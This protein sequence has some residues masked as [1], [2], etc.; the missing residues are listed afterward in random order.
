MQFAIAQG[1]QGQPLKRNAK[2]AR[3]R[4]TVAINNHPH[5]SSPSEI[6]AME[7]VTSEC[8]LARIAEEALIAVRIV[9]N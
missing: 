6:N 4:M 3:S 7:R 9:E 1:S 8:G 2:N 5:V